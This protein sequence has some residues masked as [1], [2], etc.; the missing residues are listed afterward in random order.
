MD[1]SNRDPEQTVVEAIPVFVQDKIAAELAEATSDTVAQIETLIA[2][3]VVA[4]EQLQVLV[5]NPENTSEE[6][7]II[8]QELIEWYQELLGVL[9]IEVTDE[10]LEEFRTQILELIKTP[11][12]I[13]TEAAAEVAGLDEGTHER[14]LFLSTS[15]HDLAQALREMLE[16][17]LGK[18][19]VAASGLALSR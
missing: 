11:L 18:V 17:E 4:T 7:T 13:P 19:T 6:E 5:S 12:A 9:D 1:I 16:R 15:A 10:L 2:M 14:K 3:M 8:N